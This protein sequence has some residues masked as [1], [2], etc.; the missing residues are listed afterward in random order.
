M[1]YQPSSKKVDAQCVIN[2]TVVSQQ[3]AKFHYTATTGPDRIGP[4]PTK[5]ADFIGDPRGPN[6]LCRR[7]GSPTKSVGSA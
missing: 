7:P 1:C 2:W 5:S 4:D 3:T 6:G